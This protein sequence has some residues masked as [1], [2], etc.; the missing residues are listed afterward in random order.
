M[1]IPI[2][3]TVFINQNDYAE[4]WVANGTDATNLII[5]AY[6]YSAK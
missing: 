4:V 6:N 2:T 5:S 3:G 1:S